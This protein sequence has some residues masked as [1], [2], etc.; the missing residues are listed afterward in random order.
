MGNKLKQ[1]REEK[2]LTQD[3]L[4]E[5]S[6][7]TRYIIS[8]I[9]NEKRKA[10]PRTIS[11]LAEALGC[12][13]ITIVTGRE[14]S[15]DLRRGLEPSSRERCLEESVNLTRKYC[16]ETG[17]DQKMMMKISGHLS[18]LIEEYES[19]PDQEK[20]EI[21]SKISDQQAKLLANNIFL[22]SKTAK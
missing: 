19:A 6:G 11:K 9:E 15:E 8:E 22:K 20:K 18:Y 16:E 12:D 3:Q 7:V 17:C 10:S 21:L 13:Y 14:R 2:N 4:A 5:A 1:L